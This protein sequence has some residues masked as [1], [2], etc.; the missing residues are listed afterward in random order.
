MGDILLRFT[1]SSVNEV[2]PGNMACN[3]INLVASDIVIWYVLRNQGE[4]ALHSTCSL[5]RADSMLLAS[6]G[7]NVFTS[8]LMSD[9]RDYKC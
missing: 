6:L 7:R 1:P 3:T 8:I 4:V 9:R 5:S 2:A